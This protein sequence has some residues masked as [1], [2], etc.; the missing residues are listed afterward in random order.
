MADIDAT[1]QERGDKYGDFREHG[2]LSQQIKHVMQTSRNWAFLPFYLQ[3]GLD[4]IA[5]K[6]G[7]MLNGDP[8]YDDNF[9]DIIGYTKLMQDR[10]ALDVA[11]GV[12]LDRSK[13][14]EDRLTIDLKFSFD[15]FAKTISN[16]D[17]RETLDLVQSLM[18]ALGFHI[19]DDGTFVDKLGGTAP[20]KLEEDEEPRVVTSDGS[21]VP[22]PAFLADPL[23]T[24]LA[25]A[26]P[27]A[28]EAGP[29]LDK[30]SVSQ[31]LGKVAWAY[32]HDKDVAT[33]MDLLPITD[34]WGFLHDEIEGGRVWLENTR[35]PVGDE[36][37]IIIL[38]AFEIPKKW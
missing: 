17:P 30:E 27:P 22:Q 26:Q 21:Q 35:K 33:V 19:S 12:K 29:K 8:F 37:E 1:L 18:A 4:M 2:R 25:D 36:D 24:A 5:H 34:K 7:R 10:A 9:H 15:D 31:F 3:E 16:G 38:G 11:A 23:R 14:P 13:V 32:T 20:F 6:I 28:S